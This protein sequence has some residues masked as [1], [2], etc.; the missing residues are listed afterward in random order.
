MVVLVT[1]LF[2][3]LAG[4][5]TTI[6]VEFVALVLVIRR[7][8]RRVQ[9]EAEERSA[10][11][12]S[13]LH[14]DSFLPSSYYNKEG[15]VWVLEPEKVPKSWSMDKVPRDQKRRK[16]IFEVTPVRK[17]AKVKDRSLILTESDGSHREIQ[18]KG[19]SIAAVSATSL[20]SR[21][22]AKKYPIKVESKTSM[23]YNGS[24]TIY[25]YLE[26]SMEK[27]SWCKAL[28]LASCNDTETLEWFSK[29]CLEF[30]SYLATLNE[31]HLSLLKP[32]GFY[33]GPVDRSVK[34][35]GS[36]KVRHFL[37]KIAKKASKSGVEN[38]TS[39]T[40]ASVCEETKINEKCHS[41]QDSVLGTGVVKTASIQE[42]PNLSAEEKIGPSSTFAPSGS[43]SHTSVFSDVDSDER[44]GSDEGIPCWN[45]LTSRLFFDAKSNLGIRSFIQ[46]RIQR[47]LSNMKKPS[48]IGELTCIGIDLGNLPPYISGMRL[49]PSGMNEVWA[50][51]IDIQYSGGIVVD[52][53]TRLEVSEL[54]FEERIVD[55]NLEPSPVE[56]VKKDLLEGFEYYGK[57]LELSE[58]A[59]GVTE[60]IDEADPKQDGVKTY[61]T[62]KSGSSSASSAS[63]WKSIV[64]S[65][66]KQV[67]QVPLALAI[68]V[69]SLKGTLRLHIKPPPS[70]H[71][72]FGFT[73]MPDIDF[74][75]E[76][77]VGEHKFNSGHIALLLISRVKAAIRENLVL[78]NCEGVCIPWMLADKD[79]WIPREVAPF[80]WIKQESVIDSS[81]PGVVTAITNACRQ[82][83]SDVQE[84]GNG[85]GS[86]VERIQRQISESS[87]AHAPSSDPAI[88]SAWHSKSLQEL[89]A[90]LL[91]SDKSIAA[92]EGRKEDSPHC[93]SPSRSVVLAGEPFQV[94]EGD[95]L[96]PKRVGPRARMLGLGKKMAEKLEEK[97]RTVEDKGRHIVDRM[98]GP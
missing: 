81:Q 65:I 53:A 92:S 79:D 90:P 49:L 60:R 31:G 67:S 39:W 6:V 9:K 40:L 88:Q 20:S 28:R 93:G 47:T 87:G 54:E 62:T 80:I 63:K 41:P 22:W 91:S 69:T 75:L 16:D 82:T 24:K 85:K 64:N 73:S 77:S 26:T 98:R 52:V 19:C 89:S 59:D 35:D 36:S 58:G 72:W 71:L 37:K 84:A 1:L 56:E 68:K 55:T 15:A 11:G 43:R 61:K 25:I 48:Y 18:L 76:S 50:M 33:A 23:L 96:R 5:L 95:D 74:N 21:K 14:D 30:Q 86:K 42:A 17:N 2:G 32:S 38:K 83:T 57:Q 12:I 10:P 3:F 66:A 46:A 94:M 4:A 27:E 78:P 70:D 13:Q 7:L 8:N 51:E 44:I 29:L 34:L 97:R 45:L